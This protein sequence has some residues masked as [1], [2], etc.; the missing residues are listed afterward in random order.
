VNHEEAEKHA[1]HCTIHNTWWTVAGRTGL[2]T[3]AL[4]PLCVL[5][6]P[7]AAPSAIFSLLYTTQFPFDE[8]SIAHAPS[9][10]PT[11]IVPRCHLRRE[12]GHLTR[13]EQECCHW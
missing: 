1:V 4:F 12:L 6:A 10:R 11:R 13:H 2:I 3:F 5:F 8:L 9:G 7:K